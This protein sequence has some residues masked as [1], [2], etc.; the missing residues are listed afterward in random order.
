MA[1][2]DL[3]GTG[4]LEQTLLEAAAQGHNF[5]GGLHLSTQ[6]A[7]CRTELVKGESGQLDR[8]IIQRRLEGG[9]G[10]PG[11]GI[12][13]FIQMEP[14]GDLG[15][16]LGDGVARGLAGQ[17]GRTGNPWI[18]FNDVVVKGV[19]MQ[20]Q[21]D[22]AAALNLQGPDDLER[23]VAQHLILPVRQRQSRS[24]DDGIPGMDADRIHVLHGADGDGGVV[25]IAHYLK[26]NFLPAGDGHF[27][28]A[29]IDR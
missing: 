16:N 10:D 8:Q 27:N 6:P 11:H 25:G 17:G 12:D 22:I 2:L 21:L 14:Q 26:L 13:D 29:L 4:R 28:E 5:A 1:G 3:E 9:I 7:V 20:R 24:H 23:A 19:G 18:D 15:G